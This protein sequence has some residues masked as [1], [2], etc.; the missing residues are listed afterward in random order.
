MKLLQICDKFKIA[1]FQ[2]DISE[3]SLIKAQCLM[4]SATTRV[5]ARAGLLNMAMEETLK[6]KQYL[7]NSG[8]FQN[9]YLGPFVLSIC[10]CSLY[11]THLILGCSKD[12]EA[13]LQFVFN[14]KS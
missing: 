1:K 4:Q 5:Y 7:S 2:K 3:L 13:D 8:S 11:D 10:L 14:I 12:L 9:H 6:L